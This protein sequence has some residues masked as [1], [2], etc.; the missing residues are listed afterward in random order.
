[1]SVASQS[2]RPSQ[3]SDRIARRLQ[4]AREQLEIGDAE[5]FDVVRVRTMTRLGKDEFV[6]DAVTLEAYRVLLGA[7]RNFFQTRESPSYSQHEESALLDEVEKFANQMFAM[8]LAERRQRWQEL[9]AGVQHCLRAK[10]RLELLWPGVSL[11]LPEIR[12]EADYKSRLMGYLAELFV[13]RPA[14]RAERLDEILQAMRGD[15]KQWSAAVESVRWLHK[16]WATVAADVLERVEKLP[17]TL[18]A[19]SAAASSVSVRRDYG[20]GVGMPSIATASKPASDSGSRRGWIIFVVLAIAFGLLRFFIDVS[21]GSRV[22][23]PKSSTTSPSDEAELQRLMRALNQRPPNAPFA[24]DQS[25]PNAPS[26]GPARGPLENGTEFRPQSPVLESQL[27]RLQREAEG[28]PTFDP[29]S[30]QPPTFDPPTFDP[31][32]FDPP[33]FQPPTYRPP[34]FPTPRNP[35]PTFGPPAFRQP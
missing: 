32:T 21:P 30:F 17:E 10:A 29:P 4:W 31:P 12:G 24:P 34:T 25:S 19:A 7:Q 5:D 27:E 16:P 9:Y 11:E 2:I 35:S 1:M 15:S 23:A 22:R 13:L 20:T 3:N 14:A 8:P 18:A 26:V 33:S 6:P 28:L